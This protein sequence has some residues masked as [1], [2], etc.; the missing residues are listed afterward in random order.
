MLDGAGQEP[1]P[2]KNKTTE[3]MVD[4]V[5]GVLQTWRNNINAAYKLNFEV[6]VKDLCNELR[7]E[8][9][10]DRD[11]EAE[12]HVSHVN[13]KTVESIIDKLKQKA[14]KP[15]LDEQFSGRR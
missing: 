13:E 7:L 10:A 11:L 4:Y 12:A 14:A 3:V 5:F 9:E 6:R 2:P 15:W 1:Q 8:G